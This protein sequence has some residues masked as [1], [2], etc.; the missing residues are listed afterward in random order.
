MRVSEEEFERLQRHQATKP[1]TGKPTQRRQ[2]AGKRS[3]KPRPVQPANGR[4][5][6]LE[7]R[8]YEEVLLPRKLA[9]YV[10]DIQFEGFKLRLAKATFYTPDFVVVTEDCI[11]LHETKGYWEDDAR[12]KIK[13]AAE[14]FPWMQFIAIQHKQG[15]WQREEF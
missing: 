11:E 14:Q 8:Y 7:T 9:G 2:S 10:I 12:V 6:K 5:N 3:T 15:Q 13:V 4:M 1:G